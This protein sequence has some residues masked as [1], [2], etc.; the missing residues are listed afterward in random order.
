M[1]TILFHNAA[2]GGLTGKKIL[3][4]TRAAI[5]QHVVL[6]ATNAPIASVLL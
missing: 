5:K 3:Q 1:V 4:V 6:Q 2:A